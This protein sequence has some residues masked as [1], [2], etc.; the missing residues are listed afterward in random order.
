[1]IKIGIT[2]SEYGADTILQLES[3][4]GVQTTDW[5]HV[6]L[7]WSSGQPLTL[8]VNGRL[9]VPTAASLPAT[10]ILNA[11]G[12]ATI[13]K[14]GKDMGNSSW[15]GLIDDLR[16]YSRA[17]AP[18]EIQAAALADPSL[19][20]DP[21]PPNDGSI[22][23]FD[24][25]TLTWQAGDK[26]VAHDVYVGANQAAVVAAT[27]ADTTGIYRGRQTAPSYTPTPPLPWGPKYFWR[28]DEVNQDG[29]ISRGRIWNFVLGD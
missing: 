19:A 7:V 21:T 1:V 6:A 2:V 25:L 8:Y 9:D 11:F 27:P 10:G 5:Q 13:G 14:G 28:I 18:E 16:I 15:Q 29:T 20:H 26:A 24:F 4:N 22:D 17:L 3:S 12:A 23:G